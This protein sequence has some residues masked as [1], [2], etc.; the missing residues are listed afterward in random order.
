MC[1]LN[2][3]SKCGGPTENKLFTYVRYNAELARSGLDSLGLKDIAPEGVRKLDAVDG[4]PDLQ[5]IGK[6]VA[7]IS[8]DSDVFS[9]FE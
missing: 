2:S 8:V 1:N 7:K 5:R 9:A 4:V 3:E 6:A